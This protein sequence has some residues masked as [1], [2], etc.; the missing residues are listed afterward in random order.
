VCK[1][2]GGQ[3]IWGVAAVLAAAL[4][5]LSGGTHPGKAQDSGGPFGRPSGAIV[6]PP[7]FQA[8]ARNPQLVAVLRQAFL[9]EEQ[10]DCAGAI[11]RY[12]QAVKLSRADDPIQAPAF[13]SIAGCYGKL[14]R[15]QDEV[16]WAGKATSVAP[17]FPLSYLTLGN[18]YLNLGDLDHA[19]EAFQRYAALVPSS[20]HGPYS[21]GLIAERREDWPQA[22]EAYRA[23]VTA[24][25]K[26]V[27]GHFN[28]AAALANQRKYEPAIQELQQVLALDPL[29]GDAKDMLAKLRQLQQGR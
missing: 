16:V 28:L 24:D 13:N 9:L 19:G 25:P 27:E 22:E 26:F 2:E 10:G 11:D 6:L 4:L 29:A 17:D 18:G 14:E 8:A 7:E 20:P 12:Q 1:V 15:F 3:S 23:A 5:G 21:L